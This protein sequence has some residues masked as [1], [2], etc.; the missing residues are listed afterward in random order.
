MEVGFL[1]KWFGGPVRRMV[2]VYRSPVF[3]GEDTRAV[4]SPRRRCARDN[5]SIYIRLHLVFEA[6]V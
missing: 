1:G 3:D 2:P 5:Q 6:F 4:S